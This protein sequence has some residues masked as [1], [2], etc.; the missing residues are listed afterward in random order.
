MA[1]TGGTKVLV[2]TGYT[3]KSNLGTKYPIKLYVYYKIL[4][5]DPVSNTTTLSLGMYFTQVSGCSLGPWSDGG[6]SYLGT[7]SNKFDG[8]ISSQTAKTTYWIVENKEMTIN[9]NEDGSVGDISIAWRWDVNSSWAGY[10]RPSGTIGADKVTIPTIQRASS[11]SLG[12]TM[13]TNKKPGEIQTITIFKHNTD[14]KSTLTWACDTQS[15]E[16]AELTTDTSINW[17]V[18]LSLILQNPQAPQTCSITL[19]T[20]ANDGIT[21]VGAPETKSFTVENHSATK[22]TSVDGDTIGNLVEVNYDA[23]EDFTYVLQWGFEDSNSLDPAS[24]TTTFTPDLTKCANKI[25]TAI[26]G[27]LFCSLT[28]TYS[29]GNDGVEIGTDIF[30]KTISLP[31]SEKPTVTGLSMVPENILTDTNIFVKNYSKGKIS[32][33]SANPSIGSSIKRIDVQ[34][35]GRNLTIPID[36]KTIVTDN[37]LKNLNYNKVI[38]TATD[39]RDR[40][41]D[42]VEFSYVLQEYEIPKLNLQVAR[43]T[44]DW[45]KIDILGNPTWKSFNS[46]N[47][48][49]LTIQYKK[50][51]ESSYSPLENIFVDSSNEQS[52]SKTIEDL[53]E[54]STYNIRAVLT[55]SFDETVAVYSV[56]GA[57]VNYDMNKDGLGIGK[58][59]EN[60][61]LDVEG[62]GYFSEGVHVGSAAFIYDNEK[63]AIKVI[64]I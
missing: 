1:M 10:V 60:G 6:N 31:T 17:K 2:H 16:I 59:R 39:M 29:D 37:V 25:P 50:T 51:S 26:S 54:K 56:V 45:T 47:K 3:D 58:Y 13:N 21:E 33:T 64:F 7:T 27:K 19:Q 52:V 53:D 23:N 14:F 44:D 30:E 61:A 40:K 43:K 24:S 46:K 62:A 55:D 12:E 28:T 4:N 63:D 11:F 38:V 57:R 32:I 5:Q 36:S 35:D 9:H 42:A 8:K 41:S 48:A 18:P 34:V 49:S 22:I 20:Y 15:G